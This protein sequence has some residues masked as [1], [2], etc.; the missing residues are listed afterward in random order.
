M[1]EILEEKK[2]R[3]MW[4]LGTFFKLERN[5]SV[6]YERHPSEKRRQQK[7]QRERIG[8]GAGKGE[9]LDVGRVNRVGG[10]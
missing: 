5:E 8:L 2:R 1:R 4:S 10:L 6:F 3:M 7:M 9:G